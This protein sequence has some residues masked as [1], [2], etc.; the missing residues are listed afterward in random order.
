MIV[1][2]LAD[3][4][5]IQ[6]PLCGTIQQVL[7]SGPY[8]PLSIVLAF[9]KAEGT[10]AHFHKGFDELYFVLDGM[11][12]LKFHDPV[13]NQT[14]EETLGPNELCV[15]PKGTHHKVVYATPQHRLC[16]ICIPPFDPADE[17]PSGVI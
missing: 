3:Q 2:K 15:I 16:A 12:K 4:Q 7:P 17:H 1:R 14:W 11:L 5:V 8:P 13:R 10:T 9:L 6:N